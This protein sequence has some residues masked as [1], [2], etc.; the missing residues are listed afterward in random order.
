MGKHEKIYQELRKKYADEEIAGAMMIPADLTSEEQIQASEQMLAFRAKLLEQQ[1]EADRIDS[2]LLRLRFLMENYIKQEGFS[3]EHT[4]NKYFEEYLRIIKK[5]KK[6][7]AEDL[8]VHYTRLSRVLN[9]QEEPNLELIYRLEA[10]SGKTIPAVL[11][12]KLTTKRQEY[13]IK[14]DQKMR[15]REAARIKGTASQL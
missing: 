6:K 4:F 3:E 11:W 14:Q 7:L 9:D 2:D 10:H 5:T 12:W 15:A 13:R 8:D 1:T